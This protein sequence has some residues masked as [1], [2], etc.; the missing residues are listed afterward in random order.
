MC[1]P[2]VRKRI[3]DACA[4]VTGPEK[5]VPTLLLVDD[6]TQLLASLGATLEDAGYTVLRANRLD[7]AGRFIAT[8]LVDAMVLEVATE[9]GQGWDFLREVV[10]VRNLPVM[11]LSAQGR[12]EDVVAALNSGAMDYLTKPFRSNELLARLKSRLR[13]APVEVSI[14]PAM[15]FSPASVRASKKD[16]IDSPLFMDMAAEHSLLQER[17]SAEVHSGN[18]EELPLDQRLRV[19]RQRLKLSLVQIELDTKLRLWYIQAME[20]G[21]FGMLPR[22]QAER[23][24]RTYV[25][26]LGLDVERAVEDL[27]S[28]FVDLPIQPLAY[29]GGK[30]EPREFPQWIILAVAAALALVIGLGSIWFFAADQVGAIGANLRGMVVRPTVTPTPTRTPVPTLTPTRTPTPT[31]TPTPTPTI[32]PTATQIPPTPETPPSP[33]PVPS[34]AANRGPKRRF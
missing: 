4:H 23:M 25:Q 21:R 26:Y 29:L 13:V 32:I 10:D 33:A 2:L 30:P 1:A 17:Q 31:L 28:G 6:D 15:S 16:D 34:G 8:E 12:E 11:V 3:G 9:R 18:L 27:R 22:G 7:V 20:E 14:P 19:A 5:F 24:L